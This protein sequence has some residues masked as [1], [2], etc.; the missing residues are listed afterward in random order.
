MS[1]RLPRIAVFT[2]GG[3]IA[4]VPQSGVADAVPKL[5]AE[6]LIAAIPQAR[7]LAELELTSFRQYP[8]G[9]LTPEDIIELAGR[10][11][12]TGPEIDGF[13]I[14]QGTD[15]LEETSFLLDL[16]LDTDRPVV[17][18]GAMRNSGLPGAD[19]PANLLAALRVALAPQARGVGPLVVFNDE[20]HLP[21]FVRKMHSSNVAAFNSPNAGPIG[22]INEDRVRIVLRPGTHTAT[23][24]RAHLRTL[25]N[26]GIISIGLGS[27]PVD[28]SFVA[29][30]DG[31][32][33]QSFGG[34]HV[35]SMMVQSLASIAATKPVILATRTGAGE[36]Y[37]S[38]Y[39]FPGSERDL[40]ERGLVSAGTLDAFKARLL[41]T[42]LLA[43]GADRSTI[44]KRFT[45][46]TA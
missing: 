34:G 11:D 12:S 23:F 19:G 20:I 46:T 5:S 29:G 30:Y 10:I 35:P 4:S 39:A 43:S 32:V 15:T 1:A 13:V 45:E 26:V 2:L 44:D 14:T 6:E 25:P 40:L 38:T 41:L 17:L 9:D 22:W 7:N 18:T 36:I 37:E 33:V 24:E 31:L 3:T 21:R 16:L 8:S 27:P 28:P 42:L